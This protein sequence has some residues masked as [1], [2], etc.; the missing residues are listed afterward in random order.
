MWWAYFDV[1]ATVAE[2]RFRRLDSAGRARLA[3]DSYSYLHLPMVAG[4]ILF[5]LGVK[6]VLAHVGAD[7]HAVPAVALCCGVA[8]YLVAMSAFKRRN[9]GSWNV[10]RLVSAALLAILAPIATGIPALLALGLVAAIA[11]GDIAFEVVHYR[12][13][14]ERIRHGG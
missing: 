2:R 9:V 5:A 14:R 10:P 7:M 1:V 4:I 12:E 3:R 11:C 6:K 13:A 8:L